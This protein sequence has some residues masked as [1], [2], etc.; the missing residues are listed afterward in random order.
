MLSALV[1]ALA[2]FETFQHRDR[3]EPGQLGRLLA[4]CP[5]VATALV[6]FRAGEPQAIAETRACPRPPG[7]DPE[8]AQP[9]EELFG[10]VLIR[11]KAGAPASIVI[12]VGVGVRLEEVT[13]VPLGGGVQALLI[14]RHSGHHDWWSL[15]S[16]AGG[17]LR[18]IAGPD[19]QKIGKFPAREGLE[20][21]WS[22]E[23]RDGLLRFH[24]SVYRGGDPGCCPT[25][26][27]LEVDLALDPAATALRVVRVQ[28]KPPL[29]Q[30]EPAANWR[31]LGEGIEY[32][33]FSFGGNQSNDGLLHVVRVLPAKVELRV[34]LASETGGKRRTAGDWSKEYGLTVAMNAGMFD[35]DHLSNVGYLRNGAHL[36]KPRWNPKYHSALGFAPRRPGLPPMAFVDLES[37]REE[38]SIADYSVVVQNLRT[39]KGDGQNVWK[40]NR[41]AWSEAAIGADKEGRLLFLFSRTPYSVFEFNQRLLKLP[42]GVVRAMHVEGGPEASLSI[43]SGPFRLDLSGS[44]E[45]GF[46]EN[47][48]N[49]R[50]WPLPNVIGV[51]AK[52]P[53]MKATQ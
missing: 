41:R 29:R 19:F 14:R 39:I 33:T 9:D 38:A 40:P 12:P 42:L 8:V 1:F 13:P 31:A 15:I 36:N 34:L 3:L 18:F 20:R 51:S 30:A 52:A 43:R 48:E 32:A 37:G 49:S 44:Y 35:K 27:S 28:R 24:A 23:V 10:A 6:T 46:N 47:D 17:R 53:E 5:A 22:I 7:S 25:G 45:T 2:L 4:R 16:W 21:G 11:E 50:Q 26:G